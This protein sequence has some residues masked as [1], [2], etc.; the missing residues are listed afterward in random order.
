MR[1][2]GATFLT[3]YVVLLL[4]L[5]SRLIIGPLGAAGTPANVIAVAGAGWWLWVRF[6]DRARTPTQAH[7]VRTAMVVFAS[8][9]AISY[10]AATTRAINGNELSTAD[11]GMLLLA[12]WVGLVLVTDAGVPSMERLEA[13][14]RRLAMGGGLVAA[15]GLL[16]FATG[17]AYTNLIQIP[18]LETNQVLTSVLSRDSYVRPSGTALHPIE[19]GVS[20]TIL[21]PI[22]LHVA[23]HATELGRIRRW[24]PVAAIAMAIP[25]SISRSAIVG[26]VVVLAV[27][28]PTWPGRT[29]LGALCL[30]P[31]ALVV[32]FVSVPGMLGT[33]TKL[34]TGISGDDS[35]LSRT[36]S[37]PLAF[38]FI[39]RA[40]VFGRGFQ[41]FLPSYRILDNQYLG[42]LIEVGFAGVAALLG[43]FVTAILTAFVARRRF[44][45]ARSRSAA[46]ALAAA[47]AAPTA[48]LAFVDGFAFPM[49]A[50][51]TF[52]SAGLIGTVHALSRR[53]TYPQQPAQTPSKQ[54]NRTQEYG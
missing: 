41:T 5:P 12:G 15:L 19:F 36:N 54:G 34:F 30:V 18:G 1:W 35:A 45:D 25:L 6:S 39:E 43:V 38:E 7:P 29:R 51:L 8:F 42:L 4:A 27:L 47:V 16:Q 20:M 3:T 48:C 46:A 9:L 11:T 26:A 28:L 33:I 37:Y 13:V 52:L 14:L 44:T 24:F 32:V 21:L 10:I 31:V 40:P 22:C 50:G 2:D 23:L 49:M 53:A 17:R